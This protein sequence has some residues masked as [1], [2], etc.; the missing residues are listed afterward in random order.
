MSKAKALLHSAAKIIAR[1]AR[2][3]LRLLDKLDKVTPSNERREEMRARLR[4]I[5]AEAHEVEERTAC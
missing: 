1:V 3:D 2:E 4:R 5:Y